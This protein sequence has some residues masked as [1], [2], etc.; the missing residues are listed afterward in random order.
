M[1]SDAELQVGR[2]TY[3]AFMWVLGISVLV[4]MLIQSSPKSKKNFYK[5]SPYLGV[6]IGITTHG[7]S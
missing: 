6:C 1:P 7:E 2:H 4:F 3:P 5:I